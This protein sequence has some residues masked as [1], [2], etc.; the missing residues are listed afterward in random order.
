MTLCTNCKYEPFSQEEMENSKVIMYE[1]R[2]IFEVYLTILILE[3]YSCMFTSIHTNNY[4]EV[5]HYMNPAI[6]V[7][8]IYQPLCL[9]AYTF[10]YEFDALLLRFILRFLP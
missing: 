2:L 10:N 5:L 1:H 9:P 4:V 3:S 6:H 8:N 7:N